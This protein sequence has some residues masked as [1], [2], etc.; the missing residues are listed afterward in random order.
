[1]P[2]AGQMLIPWEESIQISPFHRIT[3]TE[4]KLDVG[5]AHY[6]SGSAEGR[7]FFLSKVQVESLAA[8][9]DISIVESTRLPSGNENIVHWQVVAEIHSSDGRVRKVT[10][11]YELDLRRKEEDGVDGSYIIQA[12]Q[13][14]MAQM[15]KIMSN[16][17]KRKPWQ[18]PVDDKEAWLDWVE[19]GAFEDWVMTNRHR[20]RRAE[21]GA[22]LAAIRTVLKI[23]STYTES[24]LQK[25]FYVY[26]AEVDYQKALQYGGQVGELARATLGA[27]FAHNLGLPE[28][29]VSALLDA[30]GAPAKAEED[31]E[32]KDL[33]PADNE[34]IEKLESEMLA[35]G[36][37]SRA[38]CDRRSV[39]IFNYPLSGLTK[40][41]VKIMRESLKINADASGKIPDDE[42]DG[43]REHIRQVMQLAYAQGCT[44][45]EVMEEKYWNM[46]YA[47]PAEEEEPEPEDAEQLAPK[48]EDEITD[49]QE[50]AE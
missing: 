6:M 34:D 20:I 3:R 16:P 26:R 27:S 41:H 30:M 43:F 25:P 28:G 50:K 14:K 19:K 12:R 11:T 31:E 23:K 49:T 17:N 10:R 48:A 38:V 29:Q 13:R 9:A 21:T 2:Q 46:I 40:R 47:E 36:F 44:I 8:A 42:L 4:I 22:E 45:E 32:S 7:K 24:E 33:M 18:P 15:E 39:E 1:M 5:D 37:P 35:I